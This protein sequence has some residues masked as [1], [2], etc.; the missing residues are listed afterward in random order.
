MRYA[1]VSVVAIACGGAVPDHARQ[2]TPPVAAE[3][4]RPVICN[5]LDT[6]VAECEAGNDVGCRRLA[7]LAAYGLGVAA[8]AQIFPTLER[9]CT[10][11]HVSS[12][13]W[14][15]FCQLDGDKLK[16]CDPAWIT[17]MATLCDSEAAAC[18]ELT[19][20]YAQLGDAAAELTWRTRSIAKADA[21]C[22]AGDPFSC[23]V[24]WWGYQFYRPQHDAARAA[25][26]LARIIPRLTRGCDDGDA[27]Q[28]VMV[29]QMWN[30]NE[31][32]HEAAQQAA[33]DRACQLAPETLCAAKP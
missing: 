33:T 1:A 14:T 18:L 9:S 26:L 28:C 10:A 25:E 29:M 17:A 6:C 5:E 11:G 27:I 7:N 13:V 2:A 22:T 3:P 20:I 16:G 4:A 8:R 31:P 30:Q 12:C 15:P 24:F 21:E 23:F 19:S 32:G